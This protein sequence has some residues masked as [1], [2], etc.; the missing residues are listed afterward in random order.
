[1]SGQIQRK[2]RGTF[3]TVL[4]STTEDHMLA[5]DL[6]AAFPDRRAR[7]DAE[8]TLVVVSQLP[9]AW[10]TV[11][12]EVPFTGPTPCRAE[13]KPPIPAPYH[14]VQVAAVRDES[15][16]TRP[17]QPHLAP[18]PMSLR[19]AAAYIERRALVEFGNSSGVTVAMA[20]GFCLAPP[21]SHTPWKTWFVRDAPIFVKDAVASSFAAPEDDSA[22]TTTVELGV[23]RR[24]DGALVNVCVDVDTEVVTPRATHGA[25]RLCAM[26]MMPTT[27]GGAVVLHGLAVSVSARPAASSA[28]A[29]PARDEESPS[30]N[31]NYLDTFALGVATR[32]AATRS[33]DILVLAH[34]KHFGI[35]TISARRD[36]PTRSLPLE[37]SEE[38]ADLM[39]STVTKFRVAAEQSEGGSPG[40]VVGV[41]WAE[42]RVT[43]AAAASAVP[44]LL[45]SATAVANA[46][47]PAAAN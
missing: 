28:A 9:A 1:M 44:H 41:E 16:E 17:R 5:G 26:H 3:S 30:P 20:F 8:E 38:T 11:V 39:R 25:A 2:G 43:L 14:V 27:E 40:A 45:K 4:R 7:A 32:V 35:E 15:D 36:V 6:V 18:Q 10:R 34:H 22:A 23:R 33:G 21:A 46:M 47:Q 24:V 29:S 12:S 19:D 37:G 31:R 42:R 13:S